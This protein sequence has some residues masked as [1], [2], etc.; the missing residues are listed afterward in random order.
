MSKI[1]DLTGKKFGRLTVIGRD[2]DDKN[3]R[4]MLSCMC[5]CGKKVIIRGDSVKSGNTKSCGCLFKD[6]S[7]QRLSSTTHG[8]HG[9]P[10][11][12][13][14]NNMVQRCINPKNCNYKNYG[15]RGIEV[16]DRWLKF[17]NFFEDMGI[18][19]EGLTIE[20]IDNDKGYYKENCKWDTQAEQVRN[21][22]LRKTN[23]SGIK[24]VYY[25]KMVKKYRARIQ[26]GAECFDLGYYD[27]IED[28]AI[29]REKAEEKYWGINK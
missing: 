11:Y 8:M 18:K 29:A 1:F 7:A 2:V 27:N 21:Q 3:G 4:E 19:P 26:V 23:T 6:G 10:E 13:A 9:T 5:E 25:A 20:R 12:Y 15:K 17:D 22:R 28:A 14:W 16:S 24:G